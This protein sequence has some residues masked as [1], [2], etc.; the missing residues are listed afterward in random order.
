MSI[1]KRSAA[2]DASAARA[3]VPLMPKK[4]HAAETVA[5]VRKNNKSKHRA[6]YRTALCA[7]RRSYFYI[8]QEI[9]SISRD[10]PRPNLVIWGEKLLPRNEGGMTDE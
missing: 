2:S 3:V 9:F 5:A 1:A 8:F 7:F 6:N 4:A 10:L